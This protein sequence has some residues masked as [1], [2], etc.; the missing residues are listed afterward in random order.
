VRDK[1]PWDDEGISQKLWEDLQFKPQIKAEEEYNV[2]RNESYDYS[3]D[4]SLVCQTLP[5][6]R[7]QSVVY[8]SDVITDN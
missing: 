7:A 3:R 2:Q 6:T 8:G 5:Q 4:G 1:G